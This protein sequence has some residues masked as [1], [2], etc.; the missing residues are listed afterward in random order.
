MSVGKFP[1]IAVTNLTMIGHIRVMD[2]GQGRSGVLTM[3][4]AALIQAG[5]D[6]DSLI[7]FSGAITFARAASIA[8]RRAIVTVTIDIL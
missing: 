2:L 8:R 4:L 5:G 6:S 7:A 3:T 1:L